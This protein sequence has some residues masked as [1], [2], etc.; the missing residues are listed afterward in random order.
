MKPFT[1]IEI[2]MIIFVTLAGVVWSI[3]AKQLL[4]IGFLPGFIYLLIVCLKK[5]NHLKVILTF[6]FQGFLKTKEVM[7]ILLLV[8]LLLPSWQTAGTIDGMVQLILLFIHPEFFFISAFLIALVVSM[9]LG[10]SV[11]TLSSIGI[12]LIGASVTLGLPLEITAGAL[13]SGAFVGDRTS[14]FSSAN[15][16]LSNTIEVDRKG[17]QKELWKTGSV[18]ITITFLFFLL[19]DYIVKPSKTSMINSGWINENLIVM[20]PIILLL[21]MAVLRVK[22]KT[23]FLGSIIAA[24]AI[25][26]FHQQPIDIF[27]FWEGT[28]ASGG[29]LQKMLP[30]V[31]FI[32]LAGAYNG[33]VESLQIFQSILTKWQNPSEA[34]YTQTWKTML[35][36]LCISLLAC[37]QTLPIILTGR[38]FL[39]NWS[40][41]NHQKDFARVM[42]DSSMLFAGMIPWSVLA[43][44]CSTV[45]GVPLKDYLLYAIFLWSLPIVT[46]IFSYYHT[47][48]NTSLRYEEKQAYDLN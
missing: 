34:L 15:Q 7:Y 24:L 33:I 18:G 9:V 47:K 32:G 23:C 14:P 11:G 29:G 4:L 43:I 38:T 36:S 41:S 40:Q 35:A 20:L 45:L 26:L 16:L 44:M 19:I 1:I 22:I 25:I 2:I 6:C 46:F 21:F 27:L 17:F 39:T 48:K 42:A 5:G 31:A 30:L 37:N 3:L 10:T 28:E 8:G 12:P 13:V